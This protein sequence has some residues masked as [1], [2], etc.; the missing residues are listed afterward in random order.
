MRSLVVASLLCA[1]SGTALAAGAQQS[2]P[3]CSGLQIVTAINQPNGDY[4]SIK[5]VESATDQALRLKYTSE[6]LVTD[7]LD[8][9]F[10]EVQKTTVYRSLQRKD[11]AGATLYQQRYFSG[12][13]E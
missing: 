11:L 6:R 9:H 3:L 1:V 5:T 13:P 2:V 12:M 8:G 4:E 10:G 7:M